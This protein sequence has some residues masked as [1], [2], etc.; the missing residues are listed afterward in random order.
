MTTYGLRYDLTYIEGD[1]TA[2]ALAS[3][4]VRSVGVWR[5]GAGGGLVA[6]VEEDA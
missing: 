2:Y 3:A 5:S 6:P 4:R 1:V